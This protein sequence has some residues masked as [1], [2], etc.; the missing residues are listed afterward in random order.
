VK[1]PAIGLELAVRLPH[2]ASGGAL[3]VFETVNAPGFGLP[4]HRHTEAEVFRVME[5]EYLYEVDGKRFVRLRE[6]WSAYRVG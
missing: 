6:M 4:L 3:T 1:I 2:D 5:G